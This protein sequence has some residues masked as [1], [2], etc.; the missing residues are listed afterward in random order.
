M[1][2]TTGNG[3]SGIRSLLVQHPLPDVTGLAPLSI[4]DGDAP[5][6][7]EVADALNSP[8]ADLFDVVDQRG[9]LVVRSG[10]GGFARDALRSVLGVGG[11]L[12]QSAAEL[13]KAGQSDFYQV[14]DRGMDINDPNVLFSATTLPIGFH[15]DGNEPDWVPGYF[16]LYCQQTASQG[17]ESRLVDAAEAYARLLKVGEF[18]DLLSRDFFRDEILFGNSEHAAAMAVRSRH[19]PIF[20]ED[21]WGVGFTFRYTRRRLETGHERAG[22]PLT[23]KESAFLDVM[24]AQFATAGATFALRQGDLLIVDNRRVAHDRLPYQDGQEKRSLLRA[25]IRRTP[26]QDANA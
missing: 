7:I 11:E 8:P 12:I 16:A 13:G 26:L 15:S 18:N 25:W 1:S 21:L 24:D 17:G 10:D 20:S 9:A 2:E 6:V 5:T 19:W 3:S 14:V 22:A 4:L 23:A